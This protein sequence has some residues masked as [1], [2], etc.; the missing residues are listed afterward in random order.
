MLTPLISNYSL[1]DQKRIELHF[2]K[3]LP[4]LQKDQ[5]II[6]GG[7][8]INYHLKKRGVKIPFRPFNDLDIMAKSPSVVLPSVIKDFLI[9]HYHKRKSSFFIALVDPES[10]T[11]IDI[12]DYSITPE[13]TEEVLF[14]N[15]KLRIRGVEDQLIKTILDTLKVKE[16]VKIDPKQFIDAR[17]LLKVADMSKAD[18]IW[19]VHS[20][21]KIAPNIISAFQD[22]EKT[23]KIH[24]ELLS[25]FQEAILT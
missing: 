7:L 5:F 12:F 9:Y 19:K 10:R 14:G 21:T 16:G 4:H 13:K 22:A 24:P 20:L 6:V 11:K 8:A 25:S 17:L 15:Y 23:A 3:L 18:R 2:T 1:K